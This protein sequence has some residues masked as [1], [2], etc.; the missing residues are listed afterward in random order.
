MK[1]NSTCRFNVSG[2]K[3][4]GKQCED[5]VHKFENHNFTTKVDIILKKS[6]YECVSHL[7]S[8]VPAR[9]CYT[10]AGTFFHLIKYVHSLDS[11]T[12]GSL[13][14]YTSDQ[15]PMNDNSAC[16]RNGTLVLKLREDTYLSSGLKLSKSKLSSGNKQ[17]RQHMYVGFF[18]L[19]NFS[20]TSNDSD[21]NNIRLLWF[22]QNVWKEALTFSLSFDDV[23]P[24]EG[25]DGLATFLKSGLKL[26]GTEEPNYDMLDMDGCI[27]PPLCINKDEDA[28]M[29][30]H[31]YLSYLLIGGLQ[32]NE[33]TK[34]DPY[35]SRYPSMMDIDQQFDFKVITL[36]QR[37]IPTS[38][39]KALLDVLSNNTKWFVVSTVG[40]K[41]VINAYND[42][43]EHA[44]IDDGSNDI[45]LFVNNGLYA[46]WEA[47]DCGESYSG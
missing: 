17:F 46:L 15:N 25:D 27:V 9:S 45:L 36:E 26:T 8:G 31:D 12:L 7:V 2:G 1:S 34:V 11:S 35:I 42:R 40:V 20:L 32:L 37:H 10:V 18:D 22:I 4:E 6:D 3:F 44:F 14:L 19:Q 43:S 33:R 29:E 23:S 24:F 47:N 38:T 41:N 39:V 5:L 16:I 13:K 30:T 28:L 21:R